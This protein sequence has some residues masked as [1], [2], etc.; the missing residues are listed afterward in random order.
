[1]MSR[2][3]NQIMQSLRI[4]NWQEL[5]S[6]PRTVQQDQGFHSKLFDVDNKNNKGIAFESNRLENWIK[7]KTTLF[8]FSRVLIKK[9]N[10]NE[11]YSHFQYVNIKLY[12][13]HHHHNHN[14]SRLIYSNNCIL[15]YVLKLRDLNLSR[16][17]RKSRA[18]EKKQQ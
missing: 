13:H 6:C 8:I 3:F 9:R 4:V 5:R 2:G 11:Y 14:H 15:L 7:I 1:M 18:K 10:C 16:F 12:F 17:K